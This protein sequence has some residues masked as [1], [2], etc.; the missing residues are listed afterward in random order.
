RLQV[1]SDLPTPNDAGSLQRFGRAAYLIG[2]A[3]VIVR[4]GAA[5]V[6]TDVEAGPAEWRRSIR[7]I[8]VGRRGDAQHECESERH[9]HAHQKA[10]NFQNRHLLASLLA[11]MVLS[12]PHDAAVIR[13]LTVCHAILCRWIVP[14]R[15]LSRGTG[16]RQDMGQVGESLSSNLPILLFQ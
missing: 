12:L 15:R 7:P 2:P 9:G 8:G 6:R 11:A 5:Q 10:P 4:P 3:N 16:P 1:V 13:W 14:R